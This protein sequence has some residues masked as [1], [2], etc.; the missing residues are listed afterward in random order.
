MD[1]QAAKSKK[2]RWRGRRRGGGAGGDKNLSSSAA[3]AAAATTIKNK[4]PFRRGPPAAPQLRITIRNI[5]NAEKNGTAE[6]LAPLI[7]SLISRSNEKL[8]VN[9]ELDV[10]SLETCLSDAAA[11]A[12]ARAAFEKQMKEKEG[13]SGEEENYENAKDKVDGGEAVS[14]SQPLAVVDIIPTSGK[15]LA[16]VHPTTSTLVRVMYM[17]PPRKTRRRG[18]KPGCVYLVLQAPLIPPAASTAAA[19]QG[20]T[21]SESTSAAAVPVDYSAELAK[22]RFSLVKALETMSAVAADDAKAKQEFFGVVVLESAS[23]KV[24]KRP[25]ANNRDRLEGTIFT[26]PAYSEFFEAKQKDEENR[27]ARPRPAPGGAS[28]SATAT[29]STS[30]SHLAGVASVTEDGQ[31]VSNL[32]QHLLSKRK[33]QSTSKQVD[34]LVQRRKPAAKKTTE[35]SASAAKDASK[36]SRKRKKKVP[37]GAGAK[38]GA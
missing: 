6:Q 17:V 8:N 30:T 33:E 16:L 15:P 38:A 11:V 20:G 35:P 3:A 24:W 4:L 27:K 7:K 13:G 23:Q 5:T 32:V 31:A 18:E 26:S 21:S 2:P 1:N 29:A 22:R 25:A 37:V 14:D 28:S 19:T 12:A 36:K 10:E 34:R 9:M